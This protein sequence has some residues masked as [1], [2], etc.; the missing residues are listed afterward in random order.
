[1]TPYERENPQALNGSRKQRL[2]SGSGT[3]IQEVNKLLKQFEGIRKMMR[4]VQANGNK[5]PRR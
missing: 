3:S 2:A 5:L 1:M 4:M